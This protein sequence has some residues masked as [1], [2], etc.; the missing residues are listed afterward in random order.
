ME[1]PVIPGDLAARTLGALQGL[2]GLHGGYELRPGQVAMADAV[3]KAL[4]TGQDL[5]VEAGTGTGK[6]LAYL[7][8]ILAS[9]QR[10]LLATATRQLQGQLV[11]H[12]IP[13]ALRAIG[14]PPRS[15]AVL[16]GRANYLCRHRI[17]LAVLAVPPGRPL[18]WELLAIESTARTS[19]SG[20][21]AEVA[22]VDE[23]SPIW[24][25]VT[26]TADNC[27]GAQCPQHDSC[28]V[29]QARRNAQNADL[30]VVNHHLLL[31]D[32]AVRER[33]QTGGL[34]PRV[35]AIV[36]DEAHALADV[37]TAFFG[38]TL[39]ERR[40]VAL[41]KDLRLAAKPIGDASLRE[42]IGRSLDH[43]EASARHL[44][45]WLRSQPHLAVLRGPLAIA[46]ETP[47]LDLDASL[48]EAQALLTHADLGADPVWQKAAEALYAVRT[49]LGR[50]LLPEAAGEPQARWIEQRPRDVAVLS[51]PIEVGPILQRTLL[52]ESAVRIFT[53]ATLTIAGRFGYLRER[54][55]LPRDTTSVVVPGAFDYPEQALLYLPDDVPEP[56]APGRDEAIARH[57]E[58]L[59]TAAG[60][61]LMALFSSHRAMRDASDRLRPRLQMTCLVQGEQGKEQLLQRFASEQPAVLLATMGF[62]QGV[63]LPAAALRVVALDKIPFPPPDDPLLAARA[64]RLDA[65]G[66]SSFWELSLP[67]AAIALRQGFGRL[68]RSRRHWGVVAVLDPRMRSKSYGAQLIEA[69]P[70]AR[71]AR[72]FAEVRDFLLDRM[73]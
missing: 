21:R 17:Q 44:F 29:V 58:Q 19:P 27:L 40:V 16:K 49:D 12:D 15:V 68:I 45:A 38:V 55:G 64:E 5:L 57:L 20:D 46:A 13:L 1:L 7:L 51:R 69:L 4:A 11:L 30:V 61:G 62:W 48:A 26:S 28:F 25:D 9:G 23:Q 24:P 8:P 70:P 35:G 66:I 59:A 33:W 43:V 31:A 14:G 22:S 36:I 3:A 67:T 34:L 56:F 54:L 2:A 72:N 42:T 53:S 32:Y 37:A 47:A 73:G 71:R 41:A 52:A 50:A 39:S 63:D 18:S 10:A 6:T 65:Q 60:G